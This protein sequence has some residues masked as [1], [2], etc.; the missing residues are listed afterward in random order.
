[1]PGICRSRRM[2]SNGCVARERV[3]QRLHAV[4]GILEVVLLRR[5]R[6]AGPL[7]NQLRVLDDQE[8]HDGTR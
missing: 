8:S 3:H 5:E 4:G 6:Q 1:M 7:A 2:A